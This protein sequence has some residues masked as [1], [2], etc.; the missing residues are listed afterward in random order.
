MIEMLKWLGNMP[1]RK[2]HLI[3]E[4]REQ[5]LQFLWTDILANKE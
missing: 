2:W 5:D 3:F 1:G 4:Q